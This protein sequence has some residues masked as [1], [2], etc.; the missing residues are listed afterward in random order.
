MYAQREQ[1]VWYSGRTG[2]FVDFNSGS[3]VVN[4]ANNLT[5]SEGSAMYCDP[6]TGALLLYTNGQ[7]VNN[8]VNNTL[9]NGTGLTGMS[10]A[11]ETAMI[12]PKS[13][14]NLDDFF[15]LTNNIRNVYWSEADL[16]AG[17]NGTINA[18]TKNT[19]LQDSTGERLGCAPHSNGQGGW[20]ILTSPGGLVNSYYFDATGI[21]TTPVTSVTNLFNSN[22]RERGSIIISEAFDRLVI[23]VEYQG[24]YYCD[25]D[26]TT[27]IASNFVHIPGSTNGFSAC[28]SPDGDKIYYTNGYGQQLRQYDIISGTSTVLDN[29]MSGVKLGPDGVVY[30]VTY[31]V[32]FYGTITSPN[33]VG[34]GCNYTRNGLSL[35]GCPA[36]WNLPNQSINTSE[37]LMTTANDT[38]VCPGQSVNLWA[39]PPSLNF[40]WSNGLP[41]T[42]GPHVVTPASNTTYY[43]TGTDTAGCSIDDSIVVVIGD[44]TRPTPI[45]KDTLV[46]LNGSGYVLIDSSFI[47]NGSMDNCGIQNIT[48]SKDSFT[49][50]DA[51]INIV[52]LYVTDNYGNIDSCAANVTVV[53][54]SNSVFNCKDTTIYLDAFGFARI[55]VA[56]VSSTGG[57]ALCGVDTAWIVDSV[58]DCKQTGINAIPVFYTQGNFID[59]CIANVTVV[60]TNLPVSNAGIDSSLCSIYSLA[61]YAN[62]PGVGQVGVWSFVPTSPTVPVFSNVNS[63]SS[64]VSNLQEGVYQLI[65]TVSQGACHGASDTVVITIYDQPIANAGVD[66]EMCFQTG[67]SVSAVPLNGTATGMWSVASASPSPPVYSANFPYTTV[68]GLQE[69]GQYVMVWTA[70][71]GT[72]PASTDTVVIINN[73]VP[74]AEFTQDRT[75]ICANECIQFS[76]R[77]T[78]HASGIITNYTWTIDGNVY[79]DTNPMVCFPLPGAYDVKLMV[80]SDGGCQDS[81]IKTNLIEVNP[82]PIANFSS[83]LVNDPE[84]S[85]MIQFIDQSLYGTSI[86]YDFGDGDTSNT[87]DPIHNY[88]DSGAYDVT[89]IVSNAYGCSDTIVKTIYVHILLVYTPNT[90]TPGNDIVNE[91]FKPVING[92]DPDYY[93]FRVF[94]RW[95]E[96]IYETQLKDKGWDGTF[97]GQQC[98]Q[99][100]YVWT[101]DTKFKDGDT[102]RH[103]RGHVNLLR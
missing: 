76:D 17:A 4:C 42:A 2:L 79:N 27:G 65:W 40:V 44:T 96:L 41:A 62:T 18:A 85:T 20:I 101:V 34:L 9:T 8:A 73:A 24:V 19:L 80:E 45:C 23:S 59:S 47:E 6:N 3:P 82:I 11:C 32:T 1:H 50:V 64:I 68:T 66:Q 94:N 51:G 46:Y 77:S 25:F 10:S 35:N 67:T 30:T 13:C 53:D 93:E 91:T 99:D 54:T 60:D 61:L 56:D 70:T 36:S 31:G 103:Y 22:G 21:T 98:K 43:V 28:F 87:A 63:E 49:C 14:G 55:N 29:N 37:I 58:F 57:V 5:A 71:N 100:A 86:F 88:Q 26:N 48:V 38:V 7:T 84:I 69:G 15:I 95:G 97:K 75:E 16:S 92:D 52:Y 89:Q 78:I 72:C 33:T 74:V 102:E 39:D 90:F 81:I 83:I 12:L